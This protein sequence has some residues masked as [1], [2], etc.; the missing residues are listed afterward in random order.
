MK[1]TKH[2]AELLGILLACL[3]SPLIS[4]AQSESREYLPMFDEGKTVSIYQN[5]SGNCVLYVDGD[6]LVDGRTYKKM[7]TYYASYDFLGGALSPSKPYLHRLVYQEGNKIY[8]RSD[9]RDWL[10]FDYDLQEGD[11]L[12]TLYYLPDYEESDNVEKYHWCPGVVA[13]IKDFTSPSGRPIR[14]WAIKVFHPF[15]NEH[16][17]QNNYFYEGIGF[18]GDTWDFSPIELVGYAGSYLSMAVA[19]NGEVLWDA[20]EGFYGHFE[21]NRTNRILFPEGKRISYAPI[22][23]AAP[24]VRTT[25]SYTIQGDSIMKGHP[26][27]R[28]WQETYTVTDGSS[29]PSCTERSFCYF[30]KENSKVETYVRFPETSPYGE[31]CGRDLLYFDYTLKAGDTFCTPFFHATTDAEGSPTLEL[32]KAEVTGT[33]QT[34]TP[35]GAVLKQWNLSYKVGNTTQAGTFVEGVGYLDHLPGAVLDEAD[36][37]GVEVLMCYAKND[38]VLYDAGRGF[39]NDIQHATVTTSPDSSPVLYDLSGR[40]INKCPAHGAY[41]QNGQIKLR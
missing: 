3:L 14:R 28:V 17:V 36:S 11:S 30:F 15:V 13:G 31:F 32:V 18:D 16:V 29:E 41:I 4:H 19:G 2:Y 25:W 1:T 33:T 34:Q 12:Q 8:V 40:K 21:E 20:G 27:K 9:G 26:Y 35:D 22:A 5:N 6:S 10:L 7:M 38:E 23:D 24:S 37:Q 39:I